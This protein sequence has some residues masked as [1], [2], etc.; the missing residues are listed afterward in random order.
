MSDWNPEKYLNFNAER[1]RPALDL[2]SQID[3]QDRL[4][5][6]DLGCG[7]GNV[8][9]KL[10]Y[11]WPEATVYAVDSSAAMIQNAKDTIGA[12]INWIHS[13]AEEYHFPKNVD[14]IYSNAMFQW[15]KDQKALLEK[16]SFAL[17]NNGVLAVQ[18]P[19]FWDMPLGMVIKEVAENVTWSVG[20]NGISEQIRTHSPG[21]YYDELSGL[22][23][24]INMWS[25]DYYHVL[26]SYQ[27]IIDMIETTGMKP[28]LSLLTDKEGALF[29]KK[30]LNKLRDVYPLQENGKVLLP[31]KRLFFVAV[32]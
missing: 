16:C 27:A 26:N 5:V 25:S 14:V 11:K 28:Y 23:R 17:S 18:M 22:F 32:K 19:Q 4:R 8:S 6:V 15:I 7:P 1:L 31:F 3:P 12:G 30:V 20:L 9:V 29:K 10:K 13:G 2:I 24:S 21:W